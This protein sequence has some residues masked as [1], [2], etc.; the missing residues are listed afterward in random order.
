M[1]S[2]ETDDEKSVIDVLIWFDIMKRQSRARSA[3]GMFVTRASTQGL[4]IHFLTMTHTRSVESNHHLAGE[5]PSY[6]DCDL[7]REK[8]IRETYLGADHR[9][10]KLGEEHGHVEAGIRRAE[11]Y[12]TAEPF[13]VDS[14]TGNGGTSGSRTG[15]VL[16]NALRSLSLS[17]YRIITPR[18]APY[19]FLQLLPLRRNAIQ[20]LN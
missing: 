2:T 4:D 11:T 10:R 8:E 20:T 1:R 13:V 7:G 19:S 16:I 9:L 5:N 14:R 15:V 18:N 3:I 12:I 17:P 6:N